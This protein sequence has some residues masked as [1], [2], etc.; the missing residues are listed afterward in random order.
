MHNACS[1]HTHARARRPDAAR[2]R[3]ETWRRGECVSASSPYRGGGC[4][5]C[6]WRVGYSFGVLIKP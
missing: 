2:W 5:F 6:I 3:E 4:A 1:T